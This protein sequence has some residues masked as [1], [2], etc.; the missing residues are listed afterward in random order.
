MATR[1]KRKVFLMGVGIMGL[2][3]LG[4]CIGGIFFTPLLAPGCVILGAT[5]G[6]ILKDLNPISLTNDIHNEILIIEDDGNHI[7]II[8]P[9]THHDLLLKY[10]MGELEINEH[11]NINDMGKLDI[12]E[13]NNSNNTEHQECNLKTRVRDH[14]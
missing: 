10:K 2:V 11:N 14:F 7:E 4:L 9:N 13:H 1:N 8:E 3:G 12:N 6:A 5:I